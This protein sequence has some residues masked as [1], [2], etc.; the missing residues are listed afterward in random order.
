MS[1]LVEIGKDNLNFNYQTLGSE[2]NT[3]LFL[4]GLASNLHIWD[5]VAPELLSHNKLVAIDQ[6]GHGKTD[7][8]NFGYDFQTIAEDTIEIINHLNLDNPIIVGHS[9]GGNVAVE[10]AAHYP[11]YTKGICLVDGGL[12]EISRIPGNSLDK[13]LINMAPPVWDGVYKT[14]IINRLNGRDW[15]EQ[16]GRSQGANLTEIALSN[17]LISESGE[18][19]SRLSR[20]NHMKIIEEIWK[21]KPSELFEMIK[22]PTLILNA[23]NRH[24]ASSPYHEIRKSLITEALTTIPKAKSMWLEDSIHDVPLQR[25]ELIGEIIQTHIGNGF[26]QNT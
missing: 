23:R 1:T 17:F 9:W 5:L 13:A 24:S 2:N 18:V 4:H 19:D 16:D 8:P 3:I 22:C 21:H 6:R 25:P 7:K 26:F 20:E 15:G 14:D 11:T 10:I 12:I